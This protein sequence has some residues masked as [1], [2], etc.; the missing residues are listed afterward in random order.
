MKDGAFGCRDDGGPGDGAA[1]VRRRRPRGGKVAAKISTRDIGATE[2]LGPEARVG[3][4]ARQ[5]RVSCAQCK[6]AGGRVAVGAGGREGRR[7]VEHAPGGDAGRGGGVRGA[8]SC[9]RA[10]EEEIRRRQSGDCG[11]DAL[12]GR[13]GAPH[14]VEACRVRREPARV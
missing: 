2:L 7:E 12:V 3:R 14:V 4:V 10:G 6:L 8:V 11:V 1:H 5:R 9:P 13:D